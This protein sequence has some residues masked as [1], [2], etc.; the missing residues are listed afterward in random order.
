MPDPGL[1]AAIAEAY[2]SA[3]DGVVI[4]DT[5][6]VWHPAFTTPLRIV[7]DGRVL[8][9]RIEA[10]ATRDAG[11][12]TSFI[13]LAFRLRPPESTPDAPG[14]L[15]AE[16]DT[17][18]REIVAEIDAAVV[19][20]DPIEIVWRRYIADAALDGPDYVVR[21]LTLRSVSAGV[22]RMTAQAAWAD[23]VNERFPRL[24][25]GRDRFPTLE[26]GG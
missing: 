21:G 26:Y 2:A 15:E 5:L 16:I 7:A 6:E 17:A 10:D 13:P 24:S 22:M 8:D 9:A 23:L 19:T 11:A 1:S 20:L 25:Y 4:L 18:G 12:V 14:V 3:P